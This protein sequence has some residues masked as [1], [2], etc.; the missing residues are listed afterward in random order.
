VPPLARTIFAIITRTRLTGNASGGASGGSTGSGSGGGTGGGG[1][2]SGGGTGPHGPHQNDSGELARAFEH[3][4]FLSLS[5]STSSLNT[6]SGRSISSGPNHST[7]SAAALDPLSIE[8]RT[9]RALGRVP[10]LVAALNSGGATGHAAALSLL[11]LLD[12]PLIDR[13]AV[14]ESI[15]SCEGLTA[16]ARL[17]A[18]LRPPK[19]FDE[20][21]GS[22]LLL[23]SL[24]FFE[25]FKVSRAS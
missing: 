16:A 12:D 6:Y 9:V 24:I 22:Y 19:P 7:A 2:G 13:A 4:A 10:D 21:L 15:L 5:T 8:A 25:G 1:G 18:S 23:Q 14:R 3:G 20:R 17:Y 11:T